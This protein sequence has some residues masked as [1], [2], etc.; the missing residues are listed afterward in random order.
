MGISQ[1]LSLVAVLATVQKTLITFPQQLSAQTEQFLSIFLEAV[2]LQS[3]IL[4]IE[5]AQEN[6][7]N[8]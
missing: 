2:Y 5:G 4:K 1:R 8:T 6:F 3:L 7:G